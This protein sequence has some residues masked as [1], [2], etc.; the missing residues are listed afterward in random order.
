[1]RFGVGGEIG[2]RVE[3]HVW[4]EVGTSKN[5]KARKNSSGGRTGKCDAARIAWSISPDLCRLA[6]GMNTEELAGYFDGLNENDRVVR[7]VQADFHHGDLLRT[8]PLTCPMIVP[9]RK[10]AGNIHAALERITAMGSH[11]SDFVVR[12]SRVV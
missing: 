11:G 8:P 12:H 7:R 6:P 4:S 5:A 2:E 10:G 3:T 9:A 1:M